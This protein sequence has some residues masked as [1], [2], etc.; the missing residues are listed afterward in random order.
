MARIIATILTAFFI[1]T[2]FAAEDP[3]EKYDFKNSRWGMTKIEVMA[4]EELKPI[5]FAGPYI[6]YRATLLGKEMHLIYEFIQGRLVGAYY[7]FITRSENEHIE[8]RHLLEKKYGPPENQR[9]S[10]PN[11]YLYT[12]QTQ[13]TRITL[14]PGKAADCRIE[15]S[16]R[17]FHYLRL[18]KKEKSRKQEEETIMKNF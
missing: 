15:Y 11:D 10:G 17:K 16:S 14:K 4:L 9:D 8:I 18:K 1:T 6:T 13:A 5:S 3:D 12:W 2:A 7:I